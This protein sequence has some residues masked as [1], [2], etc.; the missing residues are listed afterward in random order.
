MAKGLGTEVKDIEYA[1]FA[2]DTVAKYGQKIK[3]GQELPQGFGYA[4]KVLSG[5]RGKELFKGII[6]PQKVLEFIQ[7]AD[8]SVKLGKYDK[9]LN[10]WKKGKTIWN[11]PYHVRNLISNQILANASTGD[12]MTVP[13]SVK[14]ALNYAGKGDT[15][16]VKD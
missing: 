4:E 7:G 2:K 8:T 5:G 10:I 1:K 15:T 11:L 14:A 6:A 9:A 3:K 12:P 16:Y 13:K